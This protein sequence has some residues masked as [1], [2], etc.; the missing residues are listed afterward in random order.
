[1]ASS[2][3]GAQIYTIRDH[4]Q[5]AQDLARS[6]KRLREDGYEAVQLSAQGPIPV[7]QIAQ[8]LRDEGLTCAATHMSL[9]EME[10]A[11][12]CGAFHAALDCKYP[13]VGGFRGDSRDAW[14][15]FADRFNHIAQGLAGHG[16]R[17][18]YHNHSH[19]LAPVDAAP[20]GEGC[21]VLDLLIERLDPSIWFEIDTYWIAHGG[22]DPAAWLDK[23]AASGPGRLPCVHV[24]DMAITSQ[25][26]HQYCEVGSGNLN[27]PAILDACRRADVEW[28]LVE[29]D[30]GEMDPFESLKISLDQMRA[31]GLS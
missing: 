16:L 14:N 1:M 26:E 30:E 15:G 20:T 21:T 18:G 2:V 27:W 12:A 11:Q 23:V 8:I 4:T 19:E 31:M 13:A 6:C 24:K 3:I 7:E 25:R 10:D 5:T 9:D 29:R 28:Y 22:G 17:V